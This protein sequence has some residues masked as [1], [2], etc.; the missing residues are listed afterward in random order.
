[1]KKHLSLGAALALT[2]TLFAAPLPA[3]AGKP[4]TVI[5]DPQGDSNFVNDQ[6][7]GDGS[8]GDFNQAGV[9]NVSD[10]RKVHLSNTATNLIISFEAIGLP[11]ATQGLGYRLRVNPESDPGTQCLLFEAFWPGATNNMTEA[12]AHFRDVCEGG[13]PVEV[14]LIG[15]TLTVPRKLSK[16]L[17]KGATLKAPQAQ[18]FVYSG[19]YPTGVIGPYMDT[20]K[21]GS[22]Y[23]LTN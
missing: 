9:G 18:S 16:A 14:E 12:H 23:K 7:T 19:T 20:T 4:K 8:F 1:M 22:D 11:P 2:A 13:D 6:G 3:S 17:G 5:E 10:L 21:V 15:G